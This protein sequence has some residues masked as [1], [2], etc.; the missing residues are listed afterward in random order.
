MLIPITPAEGAKTVVLLGIDVDAGKPP[1]VQNFEILMRDG[2]SIAIDLAASPILDRAGEII[3]FR[4][5]VR[6][7]SDISERQKAKRQRQELEE[8]LQRAQKMKAIGTLAGGVAH[9]L[10]KPYTVENLG[11]AVKK[12]LRRP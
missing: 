8:R 5:L 3:G 7:I 11:M 12:E 9:D 1:G 6:D 4:G 10:N 2:R